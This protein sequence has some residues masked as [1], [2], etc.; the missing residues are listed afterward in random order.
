MV[1]EQGLTHRAV[2]IALGIRDPECVKKWMRT[3]RRG[4]LTG[5][6]RPQGRPRQA[7][8]E[9]SELARLRMENALLKKFHT[10]LRKAALAKRNIG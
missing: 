8:D 7:P 9:A 6:Y 3:Y 4:G 2:A 10:E 1:M 5:L